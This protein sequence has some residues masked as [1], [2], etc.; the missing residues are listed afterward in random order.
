MGDGQN[1]ALPGIT[2]NSPLAERL[3]AEFAREVRIQYSMRPIFLSSQIGPPLLLLILLFFLAESGYFGEWGIKKKREGTKPAVRKV[4]F[5]RNTVAGLG[6]ILIWSTSIALAR[7]IS[8]QVGPL[9]GAA[10]VH[11]IGGASSFAFF[12]YR[13][14]GSFLPLQSLSRKY[15]VGCGALFV[16][17]MLA[18]FVSVGMAA[19]RRQ[20]L[21]IGL[22]NY[23]WPALTIL[24]SLLL[25]KKKG[26]FTL[27][28]G[29]LLALSGVFLVLTQGQSIS[30]ASIIG[31]V[32]RNP[33]AYALGLAA[34]LSWALYSNL[35]RRWG[36]PEARG[37]VELFI[38]V[39]GV[40]FLLL[41]W[42]AGGGRAWTW[43]AGLEVTFLG[44]ATALAYILWDLAMRR[45]DIIFVAASSYFTPFFSTLLSC[46]YL[47]VSA[48]LTLWLGC[49]LIVAGSLLSWAS[50]SEKR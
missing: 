34:A 12:L 1:K 18:L 30:P 2:R 36:S 10:A 13:S 27:I 17:Y 22:L 31:N 21:E 42:M 35:T 20:V 9:A 28:P 38:L 11:L 44:L 23:L 33:A 41:S 46:I 37:A 19:D 7:S 16:L 32:S 45:G 26:G 6:A 25:L 29:T 3:N 4:H 43:R 15:L 47:Q 40:V 48:G 5:D 8:E 50:I 39:T 14:K 24:F 49:G